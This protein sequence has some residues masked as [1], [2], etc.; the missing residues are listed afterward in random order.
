MKTT[1]SGAIAAGAK[2]FSL[3]SREGVTGGVDVEVGGESALDHKETVTV[4]AS[5]DG[6]SAV[7]PINGSFK[8]AHPAGASASVVAAHA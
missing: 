4:A 6:Q 8:F 3:V 1:T 2:S 7:I 5:Y